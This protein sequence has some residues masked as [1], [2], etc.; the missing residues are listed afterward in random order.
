MKILK[1]VGW[2]VV[3]VVF[4]FGLFLLYSTVFWYNPPQK[5]ILSE[6]QHP[7]SLS[8]D[9]VY[10]VVSWN[11]GYS[12]LGDNMDFFYDGGKKVR[13]SYVRTQ[14]NL[15]SITHFLKRES[16]NPFIFIQEIDLH[17]RRSYY[18]NQLNAF[19]RQIPD[20]HS[21]ALNYKVDFVPVPFK[22][23][24][25]MVRSGIVTFSHFIPEQSVRYA[26]PGSFSWP[27]RL[28]QLR[29]CMLVNRYPLKG[30]RE[31][32]LVNSHLSAFDKGELK[33]QEMNFLRDFILDEYEKGNFVIAGGDWNQSPPGF[34]LTAFGPGY[35]SKSFLLTNIPDDF[36]PEGWKWAFDPTEPTNRYLD[37]AFKKG[38]TY[39]CIIDFFLVSPNIEVVMNKT[40]NLNFRNSDHNPVLMQFRLKK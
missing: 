33:R 9:S 34:S 11:I 8:C 26:Y 2:I 25:G 1:Y 39:T 21:L 4:G 18:T 22:S 17:S 40:F 37:K 32:V 13:D 31:L 23:P 15:D 27:T 24:Y 12:G 6:N 36:M 29:R 10:S 30:G 7:D 35:Q 14:I 28:F 5:L 38:E 19:A 20:F 3:A 16:S